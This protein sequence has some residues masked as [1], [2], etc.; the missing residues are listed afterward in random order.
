MP[1]ALCFAARISIVGRSP[2]A[3]HPAWLLDRARRRR[4]AQQ[5]AEGRNRNH[6]RDSSQ[7]FQVSV[8][9]QARQRDREIPVFQRTASL[10]RPDHRPRLQRSGALGRRQHLVCRGFRTGRT[11]LAKRFQPSST[12]RHVGTFR[13]SPS[14]RRSFILAPRPAAPKPGAPPLH[15]ALLKNR[16]RARSGAWALLP[17]ADILACRGVYV[18]TS[19]GYIHEQIMATGLDYAP[20]V[21][22]FPA[23]DGSS[24][25]PEHERQGGV[26]ASGIRLSQC[27]QCRL[28]HR[29]EH[30][31]LHREQ[32]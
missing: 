26:H 15:H 8:E 13:L 12:A 21:K 25:A 28:V 29:P 20:P 4:G 3:R 2:R 18:V 32:L 31:G 30:S 5:L 27:C 1:L 24:F 17:A 9:A 6:H 7:R 16:S 19:D 22:F 11:G 10:S 23:P 14:R